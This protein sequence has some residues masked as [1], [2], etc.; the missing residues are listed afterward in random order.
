M[1]SNLKNTVKNIALSKKLDWTETR[2]KNVWNIENDFNRGRITVDGAIG[3]L[4]NEF[5]PGL[6]QSDYQEIK[7][8]L[9]RIK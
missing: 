2:E 3:A 8:R 9:E 4:E 5:R 7:R 6:S 1:F